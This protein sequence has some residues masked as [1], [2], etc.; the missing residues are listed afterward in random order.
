MKRIIFSL[1]FL[2]SFG[3]VMAQGDIPTTKPLEINKKKK[4][5]VLP[6]SSG[7][8]L[9]IP[10]VLD[11]KL[12]KEKK[13]VSMLPQKKLVQ[14]GTGMKID[15][16]IAQGEGAKNKPTGD[17]YLGDIKTKSKFV[18]LHLRDH[19]RI[20]GDRVMTI[21]NKDIIEYN[22][23]LTGSFKTLRIELKEGFNTIEFQALNQGFE[24]LN[25]SQFVITDDKNQVLY[26]NGWYLSTNSKA[27][28]IVVKTPTLENPL[29][30][31]SKEDQSQ[32]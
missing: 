6:S 18:V 13:G 2:A 7:T 3:A 28:I 32:N 21:L 26:N 14:A 25:T 29:E 12:V 5:D 22:K 11:E 8:A 24:G 31:K 10:S 23:V 9:R 20:D 15:P 19:G 27:S 30:E 4:L 16:K 1:L 17:V